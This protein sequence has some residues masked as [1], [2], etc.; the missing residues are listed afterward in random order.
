[1]LF[2]KRRARDNKRLTIDFIKESHKIGFYEILT[3]DAGKFRNVKV[4]YSGKEA[5][6]YFKVPEMMRLLCEDIEFAI[7]KLSKL[8][9]EEFIKRLIEILA[10]FQ[11]RFLYIHPFLD[12]NGRMARML[13]NYI[14][15]RLN[16]PII[17]IKAEKG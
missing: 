1:M 7:S 8:S 10:N 6:H 13:T 11:H 12:Y 4:I 14:L 17:E 2:L 16:L 3:K 15:I 5:P 9:E